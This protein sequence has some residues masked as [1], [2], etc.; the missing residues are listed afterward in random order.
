MAFLRLSAT[1]PL[2]SLLN[3]L[4]D[5]M[6]GKGFLPSM[7]ECWRTGVDRVEDEALSVLMVDRGLPCTS[8]RM[9]YWGAIGSAKTRVVGISHS[10]S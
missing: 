8:T 3:I 1:R 6:A 9:V 2:S 7:N 5:T 4:R 10:L